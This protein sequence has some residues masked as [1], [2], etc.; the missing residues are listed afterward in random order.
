MRRPSPRSPEASDAAMVKRAVSC[1]CVSSAAE[2]VRRLTIAARKV[3]LG[4]VAWSIAPLLRVHLLRQTL[5]AAPRRR[6]E[7][8][9]PGNRYASALVIMIGRGSRRERITGGKL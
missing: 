7:Q 5:R 1:A 4:K 2:S 3:R 6:A 8:Y 9:A